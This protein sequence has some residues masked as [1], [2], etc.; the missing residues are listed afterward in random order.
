M[1]GMVDFV[2]RLAGGVMGPPGDRARLSILMYHRV[3]REPDPLTG[4]VDARAFEIQ[5][6]VLARH[7][8]VLQLSEAAARLADG[9]LPARAACV[10]FDDGYRDNVEVAV[11]ILQRHRVPATFFIATGF[12]DG[13][14]MFNDTVIEAVRRLEGPGLDLQP[15]GLG[16]LPVADIDQRRAA[17]GTILGQ[18]KYL[19]PQQRQRLVD[20][21]ARFAG[22]S[23]PDDLMMRS[24]QVRLLVRPGFEVGA[25]TVNHPILASID[26]QSA[27][28]EIATNRAVLEGL[29]GQRI[30]LFAYPN[31]VPDRDY[32]KVHVA[33][34]RS[35]GF[36]A[37]VSTAWGAAGRNADRFQ[38]PRFTP[39]DRNPA[40]F[41]LRLLHNAWVRGDHFAV[42][43]EGAA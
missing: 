27:K 7:F 29:T 16:T 30:G 14:R 31:G 32:R 9:T 2:L 10:T 15:L 18:V 34:V 5:M 40:R 41:A 37:A 3:L 42:A 13:G 20:Q 6:R 12:L 11:P 39:W 28:E 17:I 8:N 22:A 21:L 1:S 35:L 24:E 33:M 43:T 23:L 25:H 38:L 4:E 26:A 36:D 19:E